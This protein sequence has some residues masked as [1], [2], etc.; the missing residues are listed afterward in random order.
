MILCAC[1]CNQEIIFKKY[2]K[3]VGIPK[4]IRG[5]NMRGKTAWNK[6]ILHTEQHKINISIGIRNSEKF[7][8]AIKNSY[9]KV[10]SFKGKHHTEESKQKNREKHLGQIP[11]NKIGDGINSLNIRGMIEYKEW[12]LQIFGRDNFTCQECRMRGIYL[13]P[14]HINGVSIILKEYNIQTLDDARNCNELW[15][16]NNGKT[17]CTDCHSKTDNYKGRGINMI[18]K[19]KGD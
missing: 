3:Y 7:Q 2:H 10:S 16:L 5:H 8:E 11:W 18:N 13:E 14:H 12:R 15:N 4:Y 6:N 1:G 19:N 9:G 17:L